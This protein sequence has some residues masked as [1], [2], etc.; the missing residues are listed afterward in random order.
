MGV[1]SAVALVVAGGVAGVGESGL[2]GHR[3]SSG[4]RGVMAAIGRAL[5]DGTLPVERAA[6]EEAVAGLLDRVEQLIAGL[7]PHA[8]AEL[9]QLLALLSSDPGRRWF[10]GLAV[11]WADASVTELQNA[12]RSMRFSSLALRQQ[13]YLALHDIV[14]AAYFA[15]AG[16]WGA[17]GYPGPMAM[18]A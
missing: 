10:A 13:A 6:K 11:P 18:P 12:L 7:P 14:G 5:L 4:A 3:L 2:Q 15:D 16:T 17:I 9:S 8:H 1:L